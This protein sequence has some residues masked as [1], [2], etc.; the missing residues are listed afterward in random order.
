MALRTRGRLAGL[1]LWLL[2]L[3][4]VLGVLDVLLLAPATLQILHL[5]GADIF[6]IVLVIIAWEAIATSRPPTYT[7]RAAQRVGG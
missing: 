5:L 7:D 2:A 3:Q 6:W 1:L 4:I